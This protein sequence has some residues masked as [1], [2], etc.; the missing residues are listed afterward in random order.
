MN[1][2]FISISIS[3]T[4]T[5][6]ATPHHQQPATSK[7]LLQND[8]NQTKPKDGELC[9]PT[10]ETFTRGKYSS[11]QSF[12]HTESRSNTCCRLK[13]KQSRPSYN[14]ILFVCTLII[15]VPI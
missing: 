3:D 7:L 6:T 9:I 5:T 2:S 10:R 14:F 8:P 15:D 12:L 13:L 11:K 1:V 4:S